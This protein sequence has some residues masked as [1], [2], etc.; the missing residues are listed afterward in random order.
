MIG[1]RAQRTTERPGLSVWERAGG[2]A[3]EYLLIFGCP[4]QLAAWR[5]GRPHVTGVTA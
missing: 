2:N 5:E 3:E 4:E 1:G